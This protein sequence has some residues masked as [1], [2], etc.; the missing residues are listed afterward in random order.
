MKTI[1]ITG[2]SGQLGTVVT[3][4]FLTKGYN[5]IAVAHNEDAFNKWPS[6]PNLHIEITDLSD[7]EKTAMFIDRMIN[8]HKRIDFAL[9]LAGGF[10]LG[11]I[12]DTKISDIKKQVS[13]N[14]DTA[15]NVVQPLFQNMLNKNSGRIILVGSRPALKSAYGKNLIAYTLSKS[16][17]FTLAELL[18]E[19]A[20]GKDVTVTVIAPS[21][22]DT[23]ANRK[24]MPE[25]NTDAW[26]KP[27]AL[28]ELFDFICSDAS[29]ILRETV[30]KA[31]NNA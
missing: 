26:V 27:E 20:K 18:N 21:T 28:A 12:K 14:F 25:A 1:L 3:N 10:A 6:H 11:G 17:L 19:T 4:G 31:Y 5:V 8:E 16:M 15:Y 13:L 24:S 9:L 23:E 30:L 7:E 22:I 2:A 29:S